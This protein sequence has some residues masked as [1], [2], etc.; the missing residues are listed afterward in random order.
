MGARMIDNHA[1]AATD[2]NKAVAI[3]VT[4]PVYNSAAVIETLCERAVR[5]LEKTGS[6]FEIIF[7]DDASADNSPELIE[8]LAKR[9]HRIKA[10]VHSEN[11]GQSAAIITGLRQA[12][13][14]IV[15]TLDDDLQH[16]PEDFIRLL[17]CREAAGPGTIVIGVRAN[18]RRPW[19]RETASWAVNALSNLFLKDP[20][21][22]NLTTFCCFSRDLARPLVGTSL[23]PGP[24]LSTLVATAKRTITVP[25][26]IDSSLVRRSRH[27]A[28]TLWRLFKQR[29]H[30]FVLHR[31]LVFTLASFFVAL[32]MAVASIRFSGVAG[33][34]MALLT[35]A[36][37]FTAF[38]GVVL[39][40]I[41]MIERRRRAAP[42]F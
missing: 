26:Y 2:A 14:L 20:L 7:V 40:L 9:D 4:V 24:W 41:S 21:P 6:P 10:I 5:S 27:S 16:R 19:W 8:A 34:G 38:F 35:W 13:G 17:Q 32:I 39:G 18:Y 31:I 37:C 30:L 3:S 12:H 22:L 33:T 15:I 23:A 28:G 1:L 25:V 42:L 36:A 29:T 11:L